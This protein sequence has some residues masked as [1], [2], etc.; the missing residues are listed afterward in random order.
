MKT[1]PTELRLR[2]LMFAALDGDAAAYRSLLAE[3]GRHL[4]RYFTRRLT[5]AFAAHAEDLV[6]ETLLAIHTRR[7][8]YDRDR[9]FTAWIHAIAHHKF[10]DHVRRQSIR[11]T[12]PLDDDA[13]IFAH[14]DNED[15]LARRDLDVVLDTVPARTSDLI[16]RTKV[17]G[18]SVAE[19]AAA[20]NM[21]ETAAK[22]SIH[23]G[24]KALAARFAGGPK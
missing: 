20:N 2:G 11:L 21:S 10:V 12:S 9:P 5:P 14:D 24:L 19:A 1:D 23:R 7:V 17:D 15:A 4:R 6:Q 18:Q 3:L 13:P 8:T 22:V 16:R